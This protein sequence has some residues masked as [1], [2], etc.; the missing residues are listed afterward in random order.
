M[1]KTKESPVPATWALESAPYWGTGTG[2]FSSKTLTS[3]SVSTTSVSIEGMEFDPDYWATWDTSTITT[4]AVGSGWTYK[5][6][7]T[8]TYKASGTWTVPSAWASLEEVTLLTIDERAAVVEAI[9]E[10]VLEN[11]RR[12]PW[13]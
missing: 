6:P 11:W 12:A 13:L 8:S 2:P 1:T 9:C 7:S 5:S 4:T 3:T 10:E